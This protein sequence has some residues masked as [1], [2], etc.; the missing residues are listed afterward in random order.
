MEKIRLEKIIKSVFTVHGRL[1]IM[2]E[3]MFI[4]LILALIFAIANG[5][6]KL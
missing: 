1:S 3:V 2:K 6:E 5:L 4:V